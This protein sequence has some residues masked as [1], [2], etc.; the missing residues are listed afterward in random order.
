MLK[1][2]VLRLR[3]EKETLEA[4]VRE[5][6][7]SEMMEVFTSMQNDFRWVLGVPVCRLLVAKGKMGGEYNKLICYHK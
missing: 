6:V 4:E 2:G 3:Q 1:R 5:Q 7:V